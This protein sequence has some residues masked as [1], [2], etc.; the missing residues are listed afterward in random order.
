MRRRIRALSRLEL[1][2]GCRARRWTAK[3]LFRGPLVAGALRLTQR[4]IHQSE[5]ADLFLYRVTVTT[6]RT[7]MCVAP[8]PTLLIVG[9]LQCCRVDL[10]ISSEEASVD[11]TQFSHVPAIQI[12]TWADRSRQTGHGMWVELQVLCSKLW[13]HLQRYRQPARA[14]RRIL[15]H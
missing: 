3:I 4:T 12:W 5:A 1:P 10:F 11:I 13:Q 7:C 15:G 2:G 8:P 6:V 14:A 9:G